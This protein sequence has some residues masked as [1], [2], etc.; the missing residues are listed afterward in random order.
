MKIAFDIGYGSIG[1]CVYL[2]RMGHLFPEI[3]GTGV[4]LMPETS[5]MAKDRS[6][7]RRMRNHIASVRNR[8]SSL[9]RVIAA[10]NVMSDEE[11]DSFKDSTP[12]FWAAKVLATNGEFK[13]SWPL[14][15]SV[16]RFYAHNRGY[17]NNCLWSSIDDETDVVRCEAANAAMEK[18]STSTMAQTMCAYLEVDPLQDKPKNLKKYFKGENFAFDRKV[19]EME[20]EAILNAHIGV[21]DKCDE[22]FRELLLG[23]WQDV[24]HYGIKKPKRFTSNKGLLFGQLLPRFDNR[25]IPECRIN[26]DKTPGAHCREA[27]RFRWLMFASNIRV[28]DGSSPRPLSAVEIAELDRVMSVYGSFSKTTVKSVLSKIVDFE[29]NIESMVFTEDMDASMI[30]DPVKKEI[31]KVLCPSISRNLPN[32]EDVEAVWKHIPSFVFGNLFRFK[33]YSLSDIANLNGVDSVC[34]KQACEKL[35]SS[36]QYKTQKTESSEKTFDDVWREKVSIRKESGRAAYSREI[37]RKACEEILRGTDPRSEGGAL[38]RTAEIEEKFALESIDKWSNNHL[39]RHRLKMLL[40]LLDDIVK[41]YADSDKTKI[42][43]ITI[44]VVKDLTA[45]SGLDVTARGEKL[46]QMTKQHRNLSE[47]LEANKEKIKDYKLTAGLIRKARIADDMGWTCPYTGKIYGYADLPNLEIEHIIPYSL[48]P[49]NSLESLVLTWPQVN[50][51]KSSRTGLAF[52]KECQGMPVAG[53]PELSVVSEQNY[54]KFVAGLRLSKNCSFDSNG[55][56]AKRVKRRKK[57]MVTEVYSE[58]NKTFLP[59]DLTQTAH[60]NKLAFRVVKQFYHGS[61]YLPKLIHIPGSITGVVR[62]NWNFLGTMVKA[63]PEILK[64]FSDENAKEHEELLT[65][66]EIRGITHLHHALDAIVMAM[67]SEVFPN[68]QD[69]YKAVL[70]RKPNAAEREILRNSGLFVFNNEGKWN[71][72][73]IDRAI[74]KN[75]EERLCEKRVVKHIPAKMSGLKVEE[76]LWR[77]LDVDKNGNVR[78]CQ[79]KTDKSGKKIRKTESISPAKLLGFHENNIMETKLSRIKAAFQ[80]KENFGLALDPQP[81]IIVFCNVWRQLQ[82]IIAANNGAFPRIIRKSDVIRVENGRYKGIWRVISIKNTTAVGIQ[83]DLQK[84]I[85][86]GK[87]KQSLK[88]NVMI[89]T[90]LKEGLKILKQRPTGID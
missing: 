4:F 86:L 79:R 47:L 82:E 14:L 25:I 24:E 34:F 6:A 68:T 74:L 58:K 59:S 85:Y 2:N 17:D 84:P 78:I 29:S 46:N 72:I 40:R 71:L 63:C 42:E 19:V 87:I 38:Y 28:I 60:L 9:R 70:K 10:M 15:W 20:F 22:N 49:S 41:R 1:W 55:D 37:M 36:C 90:L 35:F 12:W 44:E 33:S 52:V 43:S 77:I 11:L 7:K 64:K 62:K 26:G 45:F 48:R 30:A 81:K 61:G 56:D 32:M 18:Y 13:L 5:C 16:I 31:L 27:F 21:L 50:A 80:I 53:M 88:I 67:T 3:I 65:K 66:T 89:K 23:N 73:E 54:R 39:V 69:F 83:I 76:T 57:L 51:M 8:I 75:I